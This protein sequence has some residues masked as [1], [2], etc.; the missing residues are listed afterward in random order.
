MT[1]H[2]Y[3]GGW[4]GGYWHGRYWPR[5]YYRPG[6]SWFLPVLPI[7]YATFWWGGLPYYYW[8]D[9]YYTWSPAYS[10]YVAVEPPPDADAAPDDSANTDNAGGSPE[11]YVYPRNGQSEQQTATDRFECH[12]WAVD[13][14]HFDPSQSSSSGG[15]SSADYQRAITACLDARGYS[16]R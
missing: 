2:G 3:R 4:G 6:F 8:D 9:A 14:S 16:A 15:S 10:G 12:R 13:Q 1:G 7:G 5:A 11:L